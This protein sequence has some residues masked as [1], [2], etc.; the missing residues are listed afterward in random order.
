M[1][2]IKELLKSVLKKYNIN[3]FGKCDVRNKLP[4]S[5]GRDEVIEKI[6]DW[7]AE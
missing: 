5:C 4:C 3:H 6:K 7:I 2:E 1:S